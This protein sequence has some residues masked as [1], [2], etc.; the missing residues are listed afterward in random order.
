[1]QPIVIDTEITIYP[2]RLYCVAIKFAFKLSACGIE[3]SELAIV[4]SILASSI[5]MRYL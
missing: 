5:H 4:M 1:M 2:K 3:Y